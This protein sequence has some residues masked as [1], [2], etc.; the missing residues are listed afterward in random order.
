MSDTLIILTW[1]WLAA[2]I[3]IAGDQRKCGAGKSFLMSVFFSP[4]I[5]AV[6]V[7]ASKERE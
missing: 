4:V 1:L 7:L 2:G 6:F 5:G 3:G